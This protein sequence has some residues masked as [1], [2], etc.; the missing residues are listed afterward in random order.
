V[1]LTWVNFTGWRDEDPDEAVYVY[2]DKQLGKGREGFEL[3]LAELRRLPP[4]TEVT[5]YPFTA[6]HAYGDSGYHSPQPVRRVPYM[7][8]PDLSDELRR[9]VAERKL[10]VE[11]LP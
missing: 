11:R 10:N 2:N 3:V 8:M 7:S 5:I 4:G 9:I 6:F 1:S